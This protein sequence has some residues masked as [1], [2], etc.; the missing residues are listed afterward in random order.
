LLVGTAFLRLLGGSGKS[1][2]KLLDALVQKLVLADIDC[3]AR[4]LGD[5]GG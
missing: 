5:G 1:P 4:D 2:P 3:A